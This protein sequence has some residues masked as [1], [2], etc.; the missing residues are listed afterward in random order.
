MKFQH[1]ENIWKQVMK[2]IGLS[3]LNGKRM[4]GWEIKDQQ[5]KV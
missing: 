2:K 4:L 1:F 3:G 5:K